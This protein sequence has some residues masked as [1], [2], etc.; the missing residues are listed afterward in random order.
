M[1]LKYFR[2]L[3]I[4]CR[5]DQRVAIGGREESIEEGEGKFYVLG[6]AVRTVV[7]NPPGWWVY[8]NGDYHKNNY[9]GCVMRRKLLS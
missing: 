7:S 9:K 8:M 6:I 5:N 2:L 1:K 4:F 3:L